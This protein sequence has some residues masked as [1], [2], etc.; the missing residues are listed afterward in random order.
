M[1][2]SEIKPLTGIRGIAALAVLHH[3]F[4][5]KL[6]V[7]LPSLNFFSIMQQHGSIG[8]DLFFILSGFIMTYV[9]S[10]HRIP[11]TKAD[12][13]NFMIKRF[14]R[15]YPNHFVVLMF[16][17]TMWLTAHVLGISMHGDYSM[18]NFFLQL[19]LLNGYIPN[20]AW[21]YPSW[22]VSA[23]WFGYMAIFPLS[24]ILTRLGIVRKYPLVFSAGIIILYVIFLRHAPSWTN[25]TFRISTE[26]LCGVF[27]FMSW[28]DRGSN[29]ALGFAW[30]DLVALILLGGF[31]ASF[32]WTLP[33]ILVGDILVLLCPVLIYGLATQRGLL[34]KALQTKPMVYLGAISYALYI[35]HATV[36]KALKVL[37]PEAKAEGLHLS[38][39]ILIVIMHFVLPIIV[40]A[41]L[42]RFVEEPSRR[43][44]CKTL[45]P[46]KAQPTLT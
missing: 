36:E 41:I 42:Y 30:A 11:F 10:Q 5:E 18:Y 1:N 24:I 22:S 13:K 40:A 23:E 26:F 28:E 7:I 19:T 4:G 12:Y 38:L 20:S 34:A 45:L 6:E 15:I 27:L 46:K 21:N 35:S 44:I 8:V 31:A 33:T 39:R 14:A 9:Y 17:L 29:A 37:C 3:H 16:L 43:K 2:R 25:A 32:F